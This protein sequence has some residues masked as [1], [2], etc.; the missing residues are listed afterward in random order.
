ML[1]NSRGWWEAWL[2]TEEGKVEPANRAEQRA[3]TLK[4]DC[5]EL[6]WKIDWNKME[7]DRLQ[8]YIN[9]Y[10]NRMIQLQQELT[11]LGE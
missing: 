3:Y 2:E 10:H 9:T 1:E 6:Q 7:R 5:F 11:N 8:K 4:R